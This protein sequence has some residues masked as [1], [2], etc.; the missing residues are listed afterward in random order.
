MRAVPLPIRSD[1]TAES[2]HARLWEGYQVEVPITDWQGWRFVRVSIQA[3]NSEQ[4]VARLIAGLA[5]VLGLEL[6]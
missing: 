3:Y 5:A 4:D 2:L 6:S 1:L